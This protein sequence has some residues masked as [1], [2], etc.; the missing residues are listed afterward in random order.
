M[1]LICKSC[2]STNIN[3]DAWVV[4]DEQSQEWR[5]GDV[6]DEEIWCGDCEEPGWSNIEVEYYQC[7]SYLYAQRYREVQG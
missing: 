5:L 3:R 4:W 7:N 6:Y 2:G 1:K